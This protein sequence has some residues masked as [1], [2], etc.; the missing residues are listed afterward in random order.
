MFK[1]D[2]EKYLKRLIARNEVILFLGSGFSLNATNKLGEKFPTGK[3]LAEKIWSFLGYTGD[4]DG[5]SLPELYQV[6]ISD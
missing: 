6:L 1:K 3:I 5:T 4:Y 2:D